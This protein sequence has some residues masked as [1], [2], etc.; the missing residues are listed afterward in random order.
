MTRKD[1][2]HIDA[3]MA[4]PDGMKTIYADI[5]NYDNTFYIPDEVYCERDGRQLHM[6]LIYPACPE[7]MMR[8][9]ME[10]RGR[11]ALPRRAEQTSPAYPLIVYIQGSS[12]LKQDLY[13]AIPKLSRFARLGYAVASIEFRE[14]ESAK[15][16]AGIRDVKTAIRFLR[17]N[18]ETYG[19]DKDRI[20]VWGD[21]SGGH[22]A[23]MVASTGWTDEF[24]D[25]FY[26]EESSAVNCCVDFYG[27]TSLAVLN[28]APRA[29]AFAVPSDEASP[30]GKLLGVDLT[31]TPE[32]ARAAN[33][34]DYIYEDKAYPPYLIMH[35]DEDGMVP[36]DQSV[37]MYEKLK[38]CGKR[39]ELYK[40]CGA[41]HGYG[42]WT[43]EALEIV[44][45]FFKAYL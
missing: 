5:E 21:S 24:D 20:G 37:R 14:S 18:A 13:K 9:Q 35:G 33:P 22:M 26:P 38:S 44:A 34:V 10:K 40:V 19:I 36:F 41:G 31:K 16:P 8:K 7:S 32:A 27:P 30:E 42:L 3:S 17:A 15:W 2:A 25:G 23:L 1:F 43:D 29:A 28:D 45:R 12:W 4:H 11:K 6:Q 39:A